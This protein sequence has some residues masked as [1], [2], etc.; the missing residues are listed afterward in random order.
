MNINKLIETIETGGLDDKFTSLYPGADILEVRTRYLDA[1][2]NF[3]GMFGPGREVMLL[4]VPGRS[5]LSGN[6]TDHNCGCVIA[7]SVDLDIIAVAS[8]RPDRQ[9]RLKSEGL[10][11]NRVDIDKYTRPDPA[12]YGNSDSLIAGVCAGFAQSVYAVG[13]FD[14]YTT[15]KIAKGAG[16]SSSAAFEVMVGCILNHMYNGGKVDSV[17]IAKVAQYAEN[18]F[19]GKPCGLM[20]QIACAYGGIVAIDFAD[21]KSPVIEKLNFDLTKRGYNLCIVDSGGSHA[22][23]TDEYAAVAAEMRAVASHFGRACLR[24]VDEKELMSAI[25]ELRVACGDRAV[26]RAL[27][28]VGE[29]RRVAEQKQALR[30]GDLDCYFAGVRASGRSSFCYL[31]NVFSIKNAKEQGLSLA[32]CLAEKYLTGKTAAWRV[33]GGGFAGSIQAY[34]KS[35]DVEG[36]RRLMDR[37]FGREACSVLHIRR[38]GALRLC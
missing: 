36:F 17:S 2:G 14:A 35:G 23:L 7:A 16:L 28:F 11:Q 25:P 37:V 33:H 32:L 15:S 8:P 1:A 29:N 38:E 20:D 22:G 34:V 18:E 10:P 19:F 9:I 24:E 30:E 26:L 5:E 12:L 27:H 31:Q 3:L 13:G 4:S 6:H 21:P